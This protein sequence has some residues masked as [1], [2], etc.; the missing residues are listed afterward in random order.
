MSSKLM[1]LQQL[2]EAVRQLQKEGQC[3]VF[4]NGCFDILHYGHIDYIKGA[5]ELGDKLIVA[6][7]SDKSVKAYKGDDRPIICET[8][9]I[10]LLDAIRYID[11]LIVFDDPDVN[12]L[13]LTLK[14]D[15]HAKGTDYT[16]ETVP[17]RDTVKSYGGQVAIAGNPRVNSSTNIIDKILDAYG[18]EK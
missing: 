12:N 10:E 11:Y 16:V 18:K 6:V 3:V 15:I 8:E 7:N 1:N 17:E 9:R 14:P 2:T 13:L 4:C 5:R